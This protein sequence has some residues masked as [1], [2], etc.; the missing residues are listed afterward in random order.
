MEYDIDEVRSDLLNAGWCRLPAMTDIE[1]RR[2]VAELGHAWCETEVL[3]RPDVRSYL[4]RADAVPLHTDH[5]DA[6]YMSWRCGRQDNADGSQLLLDGR[7][8]LAACGPLV[9]DCLRQVHLE[10]RVRKGDPPSR[11][12]VVRCTGLGERVFFASW[13]SPVESDP[14]STNA[15][16]TLR[17]QVD[18]LSSQL[19]TSI[20]LEEGEVL[21]IDN[22]RIL[23]GRGPLSETSDRLLRRFW[24]TED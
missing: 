20:R 5:P 7:A 19:T 16:E 14:Q 13:L 4:C 12:P 23:H 17:R 18:R 24:I 22:G 1:Y 11:I 10:V 21:V 3:L 9:R 6:D 2:L 8:A 15:Y